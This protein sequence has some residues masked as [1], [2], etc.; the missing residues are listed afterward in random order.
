MNNFKN[1][2]DFTKYLKNQD[3]IFQE[4]IYP[5]DNQNMTLFSS[6]ERYF[7]N[8]ANLL[9]N[10]KR[11]NE[12]RRQIRKP[13]TKYTYD[14][15]K[16]KCK[17][18]VIENLIKFINNKIAEAYNGNIGA[19]IIKKQL[20]KLNQEQKK[21]SNADFN[22]EFLKKTVKEILSEKLSTRIKYYPEDHNKKLIEELLAE[23]G[24][25]F[26]K[27]FNL[28]FLDCVEHFIGNKEISELNG[29]TLFSELKDDIVE[30]CEDDGESYYKNLEIFLKEFEKRINNAKA[31]NK[32]SKSI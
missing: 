14:N 24:E 2:D 12:T 10:N 9:L 31:R 15:L 20:L 27:I 28:T 23:K 25:Y 29:L 11:K 8:E 16:R 3:S 13:H 4:K 30:K 32:K 1:L 7:F 21:N 17:H 6:E 22:K 19:G 5:E 26:E 18:L